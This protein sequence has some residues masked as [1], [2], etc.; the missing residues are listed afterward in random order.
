MTDKRYN[1]A[2]PLLDELIITAP[3]SVTARTLLGE[4]YLNL[5]Q[6]NEARKQLEIILEKQQYYLPAL[7]LMVRVEL[8]SSHFKQALGY[9][10]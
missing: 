4:T 5:G 10:K 2:L 1:E 9:A 6:N 3:E 7:V 8:S